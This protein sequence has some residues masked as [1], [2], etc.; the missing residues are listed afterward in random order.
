MSK[1]KLAAPAVLFLL[2]VCFFWKLA[3][4]GQY[5]FLEGYDTANQ[6]LPWLQVQVQAIRHGEIVLW[7]PYHFG[8]QSLI[9]QVQPGVTSPFTYLLAAFP[10]KHGHITVTSV[11]LW[12][13]LIHFCAALFAYLLLRDL[14]LARAPSIVGAMFFTLAGFGGN[15]EWP[16]ILAA[17]IWTPLIF[18]FL[19]R[20]L[21]GRKPFGSSAAAGFF[22]GLSWLS[23]HHQPPLFISISIACI[24]AF[25]FV[26]RYKH[27]GQLTLSAATLFTVATMVGALQV[28][29]AIEYGHTAL[30]WTTSGVL[31]WSMKV[32]YPEHEKQGLKAADLLYAIVPGGGSA[33]SNPF[34]GLVAIS[35]AGVAILLAL[36]NS[37]VRLCV[38]TA[39]GSLLFAMPRYNVFHGLFYFAIPGVEKSRSPAMALCV[40]NF[41]LA[42]LVAFGMD[43]FLKRGSSRWS[44]KISRCLATIGAG[45]FG[46]MYLMM[47][48][49][50]TVQSRL[51]EG[52]D[53]IG[54]VALIAL[55]MAGVYAAYARGH[56]ARGTAAAFTC[57]LLMVE[58]GNSAGFAWVH[59]D[60]K[61]RATFLKPIFE[62]R[63]IAEY[64]RRQP[65]PF[66]VEVN[67]EDL[68]FNFGDW[69]GIE[70]VE[71]YAPSMPAQFMELH[72]WNPRVREMYG[73]GYAIS[74]NPM[75]AEQQEVFASGSG[76]KVFR[77]PHSFPR[78]W[79]VHEAEAIQDNKQAT[80][81][82]SEGNVDL[83]KRA[84]IA[85]PRALPIEN[86]QEPDQIGTTSQGSQWLAL[87]VDMACRGLVIIGAN[88]AP[89]WRVR[90]DDRAAVMV[91]AN[92]LLRAVVVDK[93]RHRIRMEYRPG[94]V[95]AGL[96]LALLGSGAAFYLWR[97]RES[98]G[99][100]IL[101]CV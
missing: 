86:C 70:T 13:I 42:V 83:R 32:P 2:T 38:I 41:C 46:V 17:S 64:L 75:R 97:R 58:Q 68:H 50:P 31:D 69:Y 66:R 81:L 15:T 44:A 52:D 43:Y 60:D 47:F 80:H 87:D 6:V 19:V 1:S 91:T 89:G 20:A 22:L 74:R 93:G 76:L 30:R 9:G 95:Y 7:D 5:T 96:T 53:R 82:V 8:G 18:L 16:Q 65:G 71:G 40:T 92:T 39:V 90:V 4:S 27:R 36:D 29:P 33:I 3:L 88:N 11:H 94:S 100:D 59:K 57:L 85:G 62:T 37:V 79:S 77:N 78:A 73:V 34:V 21:S 45:S 72:W 10:I 63:D 98:D 23:G 49:A 56:L 35:L 84:V 55:V 48:L 51:V 54:M 61:A 25:L 26:R 28:L 99:A 14:R 24:V 67:R 12:F 101:D